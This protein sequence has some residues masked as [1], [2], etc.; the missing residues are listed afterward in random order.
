ML[1]VLMAILIASPAVFSRPKPKRSGE[2]DKG[3]YTD[4]TYGF[5]FKILDNWSY[6][7]Q[8]PDNNMRLELKQV[9]YKIPPEL[10]PYPGMAQVPDL[11]V[12]VHENDMTAGEFIDSLESQT[13]SSGDKKSILKAIYALEEK[14]FFDNLARDGKTDVMAGDLKVIK[15]QGRM[16]FT[17]R[18]GMGDEIP[19]TYGLAM[20]AV[21]H[22]KYMLNFTLVTEVGFL[23]EIVKQVDEMVASIKWE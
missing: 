12:Y 22:D 15:W 13:Y 16:N 3:V 11:E 18:L 2:V 10:M 23:N 4:Q 14:V 19:R 5:S 17:K 7:I 20:Y 1:L 8:K 21:K 9:D 6:D